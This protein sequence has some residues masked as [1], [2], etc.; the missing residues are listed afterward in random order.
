[1]NKGALVPDDFM[2]KG[3]LV[4]DDVIIG[5]VKARLAEKDCLEKGWLLDGFPRTEPSRIADTSDFISENEF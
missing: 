5:I 3:A 2:D 1:M 4:P